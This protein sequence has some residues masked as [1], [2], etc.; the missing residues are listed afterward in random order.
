VCVY[1]AMIYALIE[2][3]R[4]KKRKSLPNPFVLL[5][6]VF[7]FR[8]CLHARA[9]VRLVVI[10]LWCYYSLSDRFESFRC[11]VPA[12]TRLPRM[13]MGRASGQADRKRRAGLPCN[14]RSTVFPWSNEL[15][16]NSVVIGCTAVHQ[17]IGGYISHSV[18]NSKTADT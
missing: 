13:R 6:L 15:T 14:D 17:Q 3:E 18:V 8:W 2:I 11:V 12:K 16:T 9:N 1:V 7:D 4:T 10:I 5:S